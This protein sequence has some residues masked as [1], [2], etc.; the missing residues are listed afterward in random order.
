MY[1]LNLDKETGRIL[2]ATYPEYAPA[3]AVI[4]ETLPEDNIADYL[5]K[6]GEYV[7]DP[8]PEPEQTE[9]SPSLD[10][11]VSAVEKDVAALAEKVDVELADAD[12]ALEELGVE[13]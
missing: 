12:A 13:W 2:S 9:S 8:L 5:Y 10:E 1:A 4:V 6:D 3:D 11:R 7:H